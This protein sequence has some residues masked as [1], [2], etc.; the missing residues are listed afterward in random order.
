MGNARSN[1]ADTTTAGT[2]AVTTH[3]IAGVPTEVADVY[4]SFDHD[5]RQ[6]LL[7]LRRLILDT[8]AETDGVGAITETLKWG[9]PA[10]V[11]DETRSGSTIRL[12]PTRPGSSHDYG[13]Y[14]ICHTNLVDRF[15]SQFGDL[16]SYDGHRALLFTTGE[17]HP[18]NELRECFRAA[19]TYHLR[20]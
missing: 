3:G 16:F 19:L 11:T 6:D 13:V 12:A 10:F 20:G 14:F 1:P 9:Q 17:A 8:A 15:R 7:A 18:V 4:A 2:T 5:V